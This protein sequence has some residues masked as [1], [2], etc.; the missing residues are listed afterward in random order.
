[1]HRLNVIPSSSRSASGGARVGGDAETWRALAAAVEGEV[2]FDLHNRMLYGTDASL[3]QVAPLG[4][5]IHASVDDT[6]RGVEYCSERG[7]P[8]LPRGGGT[9]LAGQ[10]TSRAVVVDFSARCGALLSVDPGARRCTVEP[11]IT[12]DELNERLAHHSIFF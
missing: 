7:L 10:C 5:V 2:R 9:S 3:Y 4:V 12:V 6:L 1:M 8:I 11:G